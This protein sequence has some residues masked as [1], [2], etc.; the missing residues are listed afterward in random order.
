MMAARRERF[1]PDYGSEAA[2]SR[3]FKRVIGV[4]PSHYRAADE[5]PGLSTGDRA[6]NP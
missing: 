4:P 3:T 1:P 6:L 5:A 2:V